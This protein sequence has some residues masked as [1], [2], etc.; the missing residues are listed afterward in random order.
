QRAQGGQPGT[1]SMRSPPTKERGRTRPQPPSRALP[2]DVQRISAFMD[3]GYAVVFIRCTKSCCVAAGVCASCNDE[4]RPA[5]P[6]PG[7]PLAPLS[8]QHNHVEP[9]WHRGTVTQFFRRNCLG[10]KELGRRSNSAKATEFGTVT[11]GQPLR[12]SPRI[13]L[14]GTGSGG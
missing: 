11:I 4:S 9:L 8:G 2:V 12:Y 13:P 7:G 10:K 6:H 14:C 5:E 1:A 3:V